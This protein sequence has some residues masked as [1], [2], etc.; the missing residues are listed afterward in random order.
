MAILHFYCDESGKYQK[1][2]VVSICGVGA[3]ISRLSNFD[4]EWTVVLR[5]YG[6]PPEFHMARIFDL[7][8]TNGLRMPKGQSLNERID[9][10]LPFADCINDHLEIGMIQ[11]RDVPGYIRLPLEA[12]NCL[13]VPVLTHIN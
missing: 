11:A 5:S 7:N 2:P 10:L 1:K 12:K 9:A 13:V 6:L 3:E 8:Q 4:R